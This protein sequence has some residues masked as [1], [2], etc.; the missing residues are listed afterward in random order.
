[1]LT[2]QVLV[3]AMLAFSSQ[4]LA[5]PAHPTSFS[6]P[7]LSGFAPQVAH[8]PMHFQGIESH[9]L[10]VKRNIEL[11]GEPASGGNSPL[12]DLNEMM[13]AHDKLDELGQKHFQKNFGDLDM[14]QRLRIM[15]AEPDGMKTVTGLMK[16][17]R[18]IE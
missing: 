6:T 8:A 14:L 1:M 16:A 2:L 5:L 12:D 18:L 13:G 3:T 7:G 15:Q 9:P 17:A 10:K 4:V 11:G